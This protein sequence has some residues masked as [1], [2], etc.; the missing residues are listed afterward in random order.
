MK[1]IRILLLLVIP[2]VAVA[3]PGG[4]LVALNANTVIFGDSMY[5][6]IWRLEKG[7][8][9]QAVMKNFHAHWTTRGLDGH[10]YSESFQEM[11][12]AAF[13]PQRAATS[14]SARAPRRR[15]SC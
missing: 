5:N 15:R 10:I 2:A 4:G 6:A 8:K 3:H 9:P 11:G 7:K 14:S 12:G 13:C 1:A